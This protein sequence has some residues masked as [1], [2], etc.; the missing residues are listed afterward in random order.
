MNFLMLNAITMTF[1]FIMLLAVSAS[2]AICQVTA[3]I[4]APYA[5]YYNVFLN[6][7]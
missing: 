6:V 5:R 4:Y 3:L 2:K 1:G 7:I